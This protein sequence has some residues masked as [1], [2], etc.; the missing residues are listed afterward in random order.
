MD[1]IHNV[2][3][4]NYSEVVLQI[5]LIGVIRSELLWKSSK[6]SSD[7]YSVPLMTFSSS[8]TPTVTHFVS[9]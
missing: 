2:Q 8:R 4:N 7:F 1:G 3:V 5:M 9:R 6:G